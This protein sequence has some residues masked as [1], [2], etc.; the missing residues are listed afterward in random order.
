MSC[1]PMC[2]RLRPTADLAISHA[3]LEIWSGLL[4]VGMTA[5]LWLQIT[6]PGCIYSS[7]QIWCLIFV[8]HVLSKSSKQTRN[9]KEYVFHICLWENRMYK[10]F[11]ILP[12]WILTVS[13]HALQVTSLTPHAHLFLWPAW[14]QAC[15]PPMGL[16]IVKTE[17]PDSCGH[18]LEECLPSGRENVISW[19]QRIRGRFLFLPSRSHFPSN[20][21]LTHA[22]TLTSSHS[23]S[24]ESHRHTHT[25]TY[26]HSFRW[27]KM[28]PFLSAISSV[29]TYLGLGYKRQPCVFMWQNTQG[30]V[31]IW[32]RWIA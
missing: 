4:S 24:L 14:T 30:S 28:T 5:T 7:K 18:R 8:A 11:K 16:C 13:L 17:G 23:P 19:D 29:F 3:S 1:L 6:F 21:L 31:W 32:E 20:V 15:L 10:R 2:H 22:G 26:A 27:R 12:V 9:R 25:H